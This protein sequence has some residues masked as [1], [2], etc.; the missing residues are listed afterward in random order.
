M[1]SGFSDNLPLQGAFGGDPHEAACLWNHYAA[2]EPTEERHGSKEFWACCTHLEFVLSRPSEGIIQEGVPFDTTE[3]FDQLEENDKR[4]LPAL[5]YSKLVFIDKDEFYAVGAANTEI[6][7]KIY[8]PSSYKGKPVTKLGNQFG[9]GAC[10]FAGCSNITEVYI[11]DTVTAI[12]ASCF[13]GCTSLTSISAKGAT[14]VGE[15]A[16]ANTGITYAYLPSLTSIGRSCFTTAPLEEIWVGPSFSSLEQYAFSASLPFD[17]YYP[18]TVSN[19]LNVSNK[20]FIYKGRVHFLDGNNKEIDTLD[21]RG[22]T[23]LNQYAFYHCNFSTVLLSSS[24]TSIQT[25]ALAMDSLRY[26]KLYGCGAMSLQNSV[27][28][29]VTNVEKYYYG[30][31]AQWASLASGIKSL[32]ETHLYLDGEE[33]ETTILELPEGTTSITSSDF[34]GL[35]SI[36]TLRIPSTLETIPSGSLNRLTQLDEVIVDVGNN[37]FTVDDGLL[38]NIDKTRLIFCPKSKTGVVTLPDT[39]ESI[40]SSV[41]QNCDLLEGID[42]NEENLVSVG[43]NAFTNRTLVHHDLYLKEVTSIGDNAFKGSNVTSLQFGHANVS[44]GWGC[45]RDCLSLTEVTA[46]GGASFA[47]IGANC[48]E[49]CT[50]LFSF[51]FE[52]VTG[53]IS[54]SAFKGSVITEINLPDGS[55]PDK[56]CFAGMNSVTRVRLPLLHSIYATRPYSIGYYFYDAETNHNEDPTSAVLGP[57]VPPSLAHVTMSGSITSIPSGTFKGCRYLETII[58]EEGITTLGTSN[59]AFSSDNDSLRDIYL[60][61]T[62]SAINP[63][64]MGINNVTYHYNG[65]EAQWNSVTGHEKIATSDI[66]FAD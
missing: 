21:L 64:D 41:F 44:L 31:Y 42:M 28:S 26:L 19:W 63:T 49:G 15:S 50:H 51:P 52:V 10:S 32:G 39:L 18:G 29:G 53:S 7:G 61:S 54:R 57:C 13:S 47:S 1:A 6:T 17:L 35:N 4:Y 65:S 66:V 16:F 8:I 55:N 9:G 45:F 58:L 33:N 27:F 43:A 46:D 40:D 37:A 3:Y 60:P 48:F 2:V 22:R 11:P 56:F 34:T 38:Y 14:G 59:T 30:T 36:T 25:Y 24:M 62:L 20:Q 5:D 23:T 12:V